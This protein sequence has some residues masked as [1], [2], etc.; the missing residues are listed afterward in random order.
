MLMVLLEVDLHVVAQAVWKGPPPAI[1]QHTLSVGQF[2][3]PL[4]PIRTAIGVAD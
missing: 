4:Q 2:D 3:G 1:S